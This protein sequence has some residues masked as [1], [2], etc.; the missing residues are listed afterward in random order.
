MSEGQ[1]TSAAA[2]A[3]TPQG[4]PQPGGAHPHR[5]R[6]AYVALVVAL[7][8]V[9]VAVGAFSLRGPVFALFAPGAT[10]TVGPSIGPNGAVRMRP[11]A[12]GLTCPV[13]VAWSPDGASIALAGYA[14]CPTSGGPPSAQAGVV[15]RYD[16]TTGALIGRIQP[17]PLVLRDPAVTLPPVSAA[18]GRPGPYIHYLTALWSADGHTLALPFIVEQDFAPRS[19]P[20]LPNYIAP[21]PRLTTAGVLLVDMANPTGAA[22]HVVAAPYRE[23]AAPLEWDLTGDRLISG[24]LN[25]TP[26][27]SY[28]WGAAGALSAVAPL[29]QGAPAPAATGPVGDANGGANFTLWQPGE[30]APGYLRQDAGS[31]VSIVGVCQWYSQFAAW[32]PDGRYLVTPGFIGGLITGAGVTPSATALAEANTS[33]TPQFTP[34]SPA[35][36]TFCQHLAPDSHGLPAPAQAIAW[37]PDGKALAATPVPYFNDNLTAS[38]A[39]RSV[40]TLYANTTGRAYATL[41]VPTDP[42]AP[43]TNLLSAQSIWLRWSPDGGRLLLLDLYTSTFTSWPV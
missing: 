18:P 8:V 23:S 38:V 30:L 31:Y 32:S 25:L 22:T 21:T 39:A 42:Q 1:P 3:S 41:S 4:R 6:P 11:E 36:N 43:F 35:L 16:A 10:A 19:A 2:A 37:R 40:V 14:Q 26:A 5:I 7:A 24:A 27:L 12:D 17:D 13:D 29:A 28:R 20:Y 33:A 9:V 34:R 15:L